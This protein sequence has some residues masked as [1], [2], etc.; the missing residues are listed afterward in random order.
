MSQL[1]RQRIWQCGRKKNPLYLPY[2]YLIHPFS[3][4]QKICSAKPSITLTTCKRYTYVQPKVWWEETMLRRWVVDLMTGPENWWCGTFSPLGSGRLPANP[5]PPPA[6]CSAC[7][8]PVSL[9][10]KM[11]P[12]DHNGKCLWSQLPEGTVGLPF[13][14]SPM[15]NTP[16]C[17]TDDIQHTSRA[18]ESWPKWR[19]DSQ[20]VRLLQASPNH[21]NSQVIHFPKWH[22]AAALCCTETLKAW[23]VA[24]SIINE[25]CFTALD[26]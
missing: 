15:R 8:C 17:H 2:H 25:M 11:P 6:V 9:F 19:R 22:A 21:L 3:R 18:H 4:I 14:I 1:A 5:I 13:C 23:R 20:A 26:L 10:Q 7:F 16:P 24:I 12:T